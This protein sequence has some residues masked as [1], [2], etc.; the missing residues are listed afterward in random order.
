MNAAVTLSQISTNT[1]MA[2]GMSEV[3][4][5]GNG[6]HFR[7]R[8]TRTRKHK[9]LI[10]LTPEDLYDVQRLSIRSVKGIFK[11]VTEAEVKGVGCE[12]LDQ[13]VF[14]LGSGRGPRP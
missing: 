12:Q 13:V 8:I 10:T 11:V 6:V 14:E 4:A 1:K 3:R 7:V 5:E 9:I 2:I